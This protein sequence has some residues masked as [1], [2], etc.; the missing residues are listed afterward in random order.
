MKK[1][2]LAVA[3][4]ILGPSAHASDLVGVFY[5]DNLTIAVSAK[6]TGVCGDQKA[7][8]WRDASQVSIWGK[9]PACWAI[10]GNV[11]TVCPIEKG[12]IERRVCMY[13]SEEYF[14]VPASLRR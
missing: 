12:K 3:S 1:L 13:I 4:L 5:G 11:V 6:S 9:M 8:G 14:V 2:A 7:D 10:D